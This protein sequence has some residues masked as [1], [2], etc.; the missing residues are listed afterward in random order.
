[1]AGMVLYY[2]ILLKLSLCNRTGEKKIKNFFVLVL[3]V[4]AGEMF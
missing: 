2:G 3:R 1:M 4:Y